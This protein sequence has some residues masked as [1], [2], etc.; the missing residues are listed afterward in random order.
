M[1]QRLARPVRGVR[2]DAD[3]TVPA[4]PINGLLSL[5]VETEARLARA[6]PMPVGSSIMVVARRP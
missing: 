2:E 1:W 6:V 4:A 3:I 5:V